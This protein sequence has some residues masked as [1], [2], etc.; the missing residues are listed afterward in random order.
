MFK[1]KIPDIIY[2]TVTI[3]LIAVIIL[4]MYLVIAGKI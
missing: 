4:I 1:K 2:D 3:I